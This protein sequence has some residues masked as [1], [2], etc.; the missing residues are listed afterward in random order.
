MINDILQ[1]LYTIDH[2]PSHPSIKEKI[3]D[4]V[5]YL[6]KNRERSIEGLTRLLSYDPSLSIEFLK[7]AN[8]ESFGFKRKISSI[9]NALQLLDN[10]LIQLIIS[11]HP[12]IPD[13]EAYHADTEKMFL[14]LINHSMEVTIIVEYILNEV[15]DEK[16]INGDSRQELITASTIHDIGTFFLLIYFPDRIAEILMRNSESET[17]HKKR[18]DTAI[19]DHSLISSVLC[20]YW[21]L[22]SSI[23]SWIAF[24]HYP[25]SS[26]ESYRQ[27]AEILYLADSISTSFYEL[28]YPGDIYTIDERIIMRRN[29][30]EITEKLGIDITQLAEIRIHSS[31]Q[32]N[33]L[34]AELGL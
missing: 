15:L 12:V 31:I 11:Q 14:Q 33:E 28:Y 25:W 9:Q 16:V 34:H 17:I 13:L 7:I 8:S 6:D 5:S 32:L 29:L 24:H 27:G 21:T 30:I 18:D 10:V 4:V 20:E 23:R 19:P 3:Q 22:P 26:D 2:I 1:T